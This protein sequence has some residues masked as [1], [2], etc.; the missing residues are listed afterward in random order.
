MARR[1]A[2]LTFAA[3]VMLCGTQALAGS[4]ND[5]LSLLERMSTAMSQMSYQGTFVFIQGERM[6]TLR[7]TRVSDQ[8]G[9]RERLVSLSGPHREVLRDGNGVRWALGDGASVLADNSFTRP[10]FPALP[11]DS[12]SR[13]AE[14]YAFKLGGDSII[15][16]H[17]SRNVRVLPRDHY[18]Y[19]YSLWLERNTGLLLKWE[20]VDTNRKSLARLMYTDFR[21][22]AEVDRSELK[23]GRAMKKDRF[24]E[25]TLP[26]GDAGLSDAPR[27]MP[28]RLP[29]GFSLTTHRYHDGEEGEF[30]HLV[31][32][33]GLAAV[34]VYV[35]SLEDG[36]VYPE[37]AQ[38]LG[39]THAYSCESSGMRVTVVGNVPAVTVETIGRSVEPASP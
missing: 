14:S 5:P 34:S 2:I 12:E 18:R 11:K 31:F 29:P 26:A 17:P 3:G 16:G 39:T 37:M 30:E 20:L 10:F 7:I 9:V 27:W 21:M 35:E 28:S 22:G 13:A 33:D 8:D 32:S 25:T 23:P 24:V 36:A 15:A 19:G 6:E 4:S 38:R 1:L